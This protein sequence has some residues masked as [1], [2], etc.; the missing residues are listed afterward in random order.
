MSRLQLSEAS[1]G[2]ATGEP[3]LP[4][5][6]SPSTTLA[7]QGVKR[8]F[9]W[10][11][12]AASA[13]RNS[14]AVGR[15]RSSGGISPP[16]EAGAG[17]G[18]AVV[19]RVFSFS[20][21]TKPQR[22]GPVGEEHSHRSAD[23][24]IERT[25]SLFSRTFSLRK[26][27]GAPVAL[28]PSNMALSDDD[29]H[30]ALLVRRAGRS[31]EHK[32]R[33]CV[34]YKSSCTFEWYMGSGGEPSRDR[35][36]D[37]G[38]TLAVASLD[39]RTPCVFYVQGIEGDTLEC[40][41][42]SA[43]EAQKWMAAF[44]PVMS[45]AVS[46]YVLVQGK[47]G[48]KRR[49][50]LFQPTCCKLCIY[51]HEPLVLLSAGADAAAHAQPGHRSHGDVK[52]VVPRPTPV[53]PFGFA[54]FTPDGSMWELA[55]ES[56]SERA[57]WLQPMPIF[58]PLSSASLRSRAP[59]LPA[60]PIGSGTSD[61][62]GE[63][64][65]P[66]AT[67][68]VLHNSLVTAL[69]QEYYAEKERRASRCRSSQHLGSMSDAGSPATPRVSKAVGEAAAGKASPQPAPNGASV[70]VPKQSSGK[71]NTEVCNEYGWGDSEEE[72]ESDDED[73]DED[74]ADNPTPLNLGLTDR[75]LDYHQKPVLSLE[76]RR[77]IAV[78][79]QES[80][81][82]L[83]AVS[84]P[85]S[86]GARPAAEGGEDDTEKPVGASLGGETPRTHKLSAELE[87][88]RAQLE[89]LRN[90][91]RELKLQTGGERHAPAAPSRA[92]RLCRHTLPG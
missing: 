13:T 9:S 49:W 67:A 43:E 16:V 69:G 63:Y 2:R 19:K 36:P 11:R 72:D 81:V 1:L 91:N 20:R 29:Q 17:S 41:A 76:K 8:T 30:G 85:R 89:A 74:D 54:L 34:L 27:A 52:H 82:E 21:K 90:E 38:L 5:P 88:M 7:V 79:S 31:R 59:T 70:L 51:R 26:G 18:G 10:S 39:P 80:V 50:V 61:M 40:K 84:S 32:A 37:G 12:K 15:N 83:I 73:G 87:E 42:P 6:G 71:P 65:K 4:S 86:S 77:Q 22:Q 28:R 62:G 14:G 78:G 66:M 60:S 56:A 48:W 55:V 53:Q 35:R 46:G 44:A 64:G 33:Y 57:R 3:T 68:R 25:E 47:K 58:D 24:D 23:G 75:D 92:P 45:A